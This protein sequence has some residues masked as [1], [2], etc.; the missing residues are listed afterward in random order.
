MPRRGRRRIRR[1]SPLPVIALQ[2]N[3]K[4]VELDQPT[5]LLKYLDR[6]GVNQRAVAVEHNGVIVERTDYAST[7]LRDGD[8][9]EIVRM[10]GGGLLGQS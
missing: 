4:R 5:A 10:V 1:D 3:G 7:T 8:V 2:I 6:L 9:L